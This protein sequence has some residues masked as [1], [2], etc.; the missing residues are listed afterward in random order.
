MKYFETW[1]ESYDK[2][3]DFSL[4]KNMDKYVGYLRTIYELC[5]EQN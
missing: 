3:V 4:V 1:L 5:N 2:Y